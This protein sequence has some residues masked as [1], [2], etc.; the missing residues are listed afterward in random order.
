MEQVNNFKFIEQLVE[1][2]NAVLLNENKSSR[3]TKRV[4]F[5]FAALTTVLGAGAIALT[6]Y[7]FAGAITCGFVGLLTGLIFVGREEGLVVSFLTGLALFPWILS[8]FSEYRFINTMTYSLADL[9]FFLC[10]LGVIVCVV[11]VVCRLFKNLFAL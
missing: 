11:L 2:D 3:R 5:L 10:G 8:F 9:A 6:F 4:N 7:S 1:Q